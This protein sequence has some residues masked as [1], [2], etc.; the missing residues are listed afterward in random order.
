MC[1]LHRIV[2]DEGNFNVHGTEKK[3]EEK[4]RN[5]HTDR[6]RV[7]Y[8]CRTFIFTEIKQTVNKTIPSETKSREMLLPYVFDSC[9]HGMKKILCGS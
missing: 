1:V 2:V 3:R 7:Y 5:T 4:K 9:S 6:L 8:T